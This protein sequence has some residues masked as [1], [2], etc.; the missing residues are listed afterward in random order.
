[1]SSNFHVL[2]RNHVVDMLVIV[3]RETGQQLLMSDPAPVRQLFALFDHSQISKSIIFTLKMQHTQL[4]NSVSD[5]FSRFF[6]VVI[7]LFIFRVSF[8]TKNEFELIRLT[9]LQPILN[10]SL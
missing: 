10:F 3:V 6:A 1:M 8:K 4:L 5:S 9:R 7:S 2:E